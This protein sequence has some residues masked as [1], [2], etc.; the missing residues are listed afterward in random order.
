LS[1]SKGQSNRTPR[2]EP[3]D[4]FDDAQ[5]EILAKTVLDDGP[6][7][8]VFRTMVRHTRLAKRVNVLA[9][10]FLTSTHVGE[11]ARELVILRTAWRARAEYEF[12]HHLDIAYAAGLDDHDVKRLRMPGAKGWEA[13]DAALVRFADELHESAD[14]TDTTWHEVAESYTDEAMMELV[15]LG[16]F[17]RTLGGFMNAMRLDLE[18]P[19]QSIMD[20]YLGSETTSEE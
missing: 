9:G 16:G 18:E 1:D 12:A 2:I 15:F 4:H 3:L 11:R 6:P 10:L 19:W 5:S 17:Y 13:A 8:N 14:V 7:L 20:D